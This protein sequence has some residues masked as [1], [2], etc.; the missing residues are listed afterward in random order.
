MPSRSPLM[1]IGLVDQRGLGAVE[2]AHEGLEAAFVMEVLA[3]ELGV[4]QIG[5]HDMHAGIEEGEFAQAMLDRRIIEL[6]HGEGFGRGHEGDLG[7]AL[8]PAVD[9]RRGPDDLQR[10]D[11]VAMREFD[12]MLEPVAPN[13]QK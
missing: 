12:E 9:Y 10:R 7:A 11:D 1:R 13:A 5:Q 6:D 4:A 2:I 8:R 3:L